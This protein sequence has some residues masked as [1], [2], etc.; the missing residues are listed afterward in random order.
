MFLN[1]LWNFYLL[2]IKS[3]IVGLVI[4][5]SSEEKTAEVYYLFI[6]L[7]IYLLLLLLLL[8]GRQSQIKMQ[9]QNWC[10]PTCG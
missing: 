10:G 6:Y 7:F 3:F 9:L 1:N 4:K 8:F 5:I 2:G